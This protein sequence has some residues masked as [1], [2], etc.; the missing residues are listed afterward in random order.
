MKIKDTDI[1]AK[2]I[3]GED[4]NGKPIV[5]VQTTGGL[6]AV[7]KRAKDGSVESIAAA[8]HIGIMKWLAEKKEPNLKWKNNFNNSNELEKAEE[9]MF[10]RMR[11]IFFSP[12]T[13]APLPNPNG[14]LMVY[15]IDNS[16]IQIIEKSELNKTSIVSSSL[17]RDLSLNDVP[18]TL[19]DFFTENTN[20]R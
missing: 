4:E 8:P 3:A 15:N 5:Y 6:H 2:S 9:S 16:S 19:E 18:K 11:N 20:E 17:I 7:F 14:L 10:L 1:A 13:D 12:K